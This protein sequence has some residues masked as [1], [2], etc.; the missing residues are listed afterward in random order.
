M[1]KLT[2]VDRGHCGTTRR[3]RP[4]TSARTV[5]VRA[6][7]EGAGGLS[8]Q[9]ARSCRVGL[10]PGAV[11]LSAQ[12]R[13]RRGTAADRPR[14]RACP[15]GCA[16]GRPPGARRGADRRGGDHGVRGLRERPGSHRPTHTKCFYGNG[17]VPKD[18]QAARTS[19]SAGQGRWPRAAPGGWR[20]G[21]TPGLQTLDERRDNM[22]A[23]ASRGERNGV[24]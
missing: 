15:A 1:P 11:A 7:S 16:E 22:F 21:S 2:G 20:R 5:S 12:S 24:A 9:V 23:R 19:R 17:R 3:D 18:R 4:T 13:A 8:L 6:T 14:S 10:C